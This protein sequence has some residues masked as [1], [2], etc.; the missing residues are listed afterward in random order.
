MTA[1]PSKSA[2]TPPHV[3]QLRP[4][5]QP[6]I[7][8]DEV[9][10]SQ[11]ARL[12][13]AVALAVIDKSYAATTV[14]DVV[15]LSGVSRKTFYEHFSG[16]EDCFV[17]A[18]EAGR[19]R[20]FARVRAAV[21]PLPKH[22]WQARIEA[23]LDAYLA[24]MDAEPAAAW[25]FSIEVMGAGKA[26]LAARSAVLE[27]WIRQWRGLARIAQP[28]AVPSDETLLALVGGIEELVRA[29]LQRGEPLNQSPLRST[30]IALANALIGPRP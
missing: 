30:V 29:G 22:A 11:R 17:A 23:S 2:D 4:G 25:V 5:R 20:L 10:A 16:T 7:S 1:S 14:A 13:E 28:H 8:R 18:Y 26:A 24:Q 3:R 15:R 6:G 12:L 27:H 19:Q 9:R 21:E